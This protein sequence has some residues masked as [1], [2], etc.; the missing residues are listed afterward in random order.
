[1]LELYCFSP[2]L[3]VVMFSGNVLMVAIASWIWNKEIKI[4]V[5]MDVREDL[6]DSSNQSEIV[7][8][9]FFFISMVIGLGSV[10]FLLSIRIAERES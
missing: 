5:I 1:M 10:D 7:I 4:T 3:V 8:L 2:I 9:Q 6:N